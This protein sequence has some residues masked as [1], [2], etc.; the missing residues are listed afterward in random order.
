MPYG[1]RTKSTERNVIVC[2]ECHGEGIV[3]R[4]LDDWDRQDVICPV[5]SGKRCI[6]EIKMITYEKIEDATLNQNIEKIMGA[7]E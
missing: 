1:I 7:Q 2:P 6:W 5:C 3:M 4:I